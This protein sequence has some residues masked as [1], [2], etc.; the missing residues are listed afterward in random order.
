MPTPWSDEAA[1][2]EVLAKRLDPEAFE[3]PSGFGHQEFASEERDEREAAREKARSV[4]TALEPY[5]PGSGK[6]LGGV[7]VGALYLLSGNLERTAEELRGT[8]GAEGHLDHLE[9]IAA[10]I[11]AALNTN[12]SQQPVSGL[13][14]GQ[15]ERLVQEAQAEAE[16][17]K[18]TSDAHC[19]VLMRAEDV[20]LSR[21]DG[22]DV[23]DKAEEV[24]RLLTEFDAWLSFRGEFGEVLKAFRSAFGTDTSAA[25][26]EASSPTQ[27]QYPDP[28]L[29]KEGER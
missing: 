3:K 21:F 16:K 27:Q 17:W 25:A 9:G 26:M 14:N 20:L 5:I 22:L 28:Q 7:D 24:Q 8:A 19:S 29:G 12:S 18:I 1:A 15:V 10:E 2:V 4:L 13:D 6:L 11:R 23:G